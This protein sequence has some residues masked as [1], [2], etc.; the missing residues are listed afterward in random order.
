MSR[1]SW[2]IVITAA[3][4]SGL[5]SPLFPASANV[6]VGFSG[7]IL[8]SSWRLGQPFETVQYFTL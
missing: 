2:G 3:L 8:P 5:L 1:Q 7:E 4:L 6:G